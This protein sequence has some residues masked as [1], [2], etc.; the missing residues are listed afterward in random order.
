MRDATLEEQQAIQ[1]NI[2]KISKPTGVNFYEL[3]ENYLNT[4]SCY[5]CIY[6]KKCPVYWHFGNAACITIYKNKFIKD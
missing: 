1:D 5:R 6:E 3:L 2:D 4:P